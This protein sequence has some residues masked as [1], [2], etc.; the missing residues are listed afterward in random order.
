MNFQ[1][2]NSMGPKKCRSF[3]FLVFFLLFCVGDDDD[4]GQKR[5]NEGKLGQ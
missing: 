4:E 1:P 2:G 3:F 5:T